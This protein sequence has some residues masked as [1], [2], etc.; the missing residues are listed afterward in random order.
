[1]TIPTLDESI[2]ND[3]REALTNAALNG[4]ELVGMN[5][6]QVADD[7]IMYNSQFETWE[8][9]D[10]IPYVTEVRESLSPRTTQ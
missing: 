3:V 10:L 2:L 7:L 6:E 9:A 4:Y 8:I 1:M 5:D